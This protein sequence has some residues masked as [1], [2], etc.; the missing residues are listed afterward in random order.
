MMLLIVVASNASNWS[1][2]TEDVFILN[3]NTSSFELYPE[4][5]LP[6]TAQ[7]RVIAG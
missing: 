7:A 3:P 1:V 4:L 2:K 6:L 5:F